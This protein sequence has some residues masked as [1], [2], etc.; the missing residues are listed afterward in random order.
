LTNLT[1]NTTYCIRVSSTDQ[2][3]NG[4]T[5]ATYS[6][7]TAAD[8]DVTPPTVLSV[9]YVTTYISATVSFT[10]NELGNTFVNYGLTTSYGQ[11]VG[12]SQDVL[13]H[14]ITL[15]NLQSNTTYNY[16]VGSIDKSGNESQTVNYSFK[17]A[18]APDTTPPVIPTG[19]AGVSGNAQ[20]YL[21]WK[22][23]TESDLAG[24]NV[25]RLSGS[26]T[27]AIATSITDTVYYHTG[28]TNGTTYSYFVSAADNRQPI[29][30]VSAKSARVNIIPFAGNSPSVPVLS[31]PSTGQHIRNSEINLVITNS[32]K[33]AGRLLLTYEYIISESNDFANQVAYGRNVQEGSSTTVWSAGVTLNNGQTYYW[34]ARAYD[35]YFSSDW[36]SSQSFVA[37]ASIPTAVAIM[38]F[39]GTDKNGVVELTWETSR[40]QNNAGFNV[41]R[42]IEEKGKYEKV[43]NALVA[44]GAKH[45]SLLD[46]GVK[47][48]RT[49]YYR[50]ESVNNIGLKEALSTVAVIVSAPRTFV[51][52]QNYPNPFNPRTT[53][54]FELP[55][56]A[57]VKIKI[58]N[59]LGQEVRI[60]LDAAKE[61]GF[62]SVI[63]DG[64]NNI[65]VPVASGMY[66]Y[67]IVAGEYRAAKKMILIR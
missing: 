17:T 52:Y 33:P 41:Y 51:L 4:P 40:E 67:E 66:I 28:L 58:Y 2:S 54:K 22:R 59:A 35:G 14:S 39:W 20:V 16:K 25:Y 55:K 5:T 29:A 37:D 43:N 15:T 30:N 48:G 38:G 12:N 46:T 3:G 26:D 9:S 1:G 21:K 60:L 65:G 10:T 44:G 27:I 8:P 53:I 61:A 36:S 57:Q 45:Y 47:T 50:L 6:F 32:M 42:S 63:W 62:H 11:S 49:Y 7:K 23:N 56:Q 13:Q 34:K 31:W 18:A 64:C 24:Y 19:F